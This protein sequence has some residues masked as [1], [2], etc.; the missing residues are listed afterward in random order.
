MKTLKWLQNVF[1]SSMMILFVALILFISLGIGGCGT[2]T[3]NGM[4]SLPVQV[5]SDAK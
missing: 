3:G 4:S 1:S 2:S 5:S